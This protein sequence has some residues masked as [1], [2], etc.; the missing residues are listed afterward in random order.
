LQRLRRL[1]QQRENGRETRSLLL[2]ESD[3]ERSLRLLELVYFRWNWKSSAYFLVS[4]V[5]NWIRVE[6]PWDYLDWILPE[7]SEPAQLQSSS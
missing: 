4:M 1:R 7:V 5:L 6:S 3:M 2:E